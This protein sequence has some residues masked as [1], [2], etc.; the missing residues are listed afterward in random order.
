[1]AEGCSWS[2]SFWSRIRL[3]RLDLAEAGRRPWGAG[4]GQEEAGFRVAEGSGR[5]DCEG[6]VSQTPG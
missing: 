6:D 3:G 2:Q 4:G 5:P 1:M